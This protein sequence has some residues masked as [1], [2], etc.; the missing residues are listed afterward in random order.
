MQLCC[1]KKMLDELGVV[2]QSESEENDLFCWSANLITVNRKK[3]IV[4]V[5]DKNRFGYVLYGLKV[6]DLKSLDKF[7][8]EGIKAAFRD[9]KIKEE[10]I[11]KYLQAAGD[12]V[13]AR[14]RGPKYVSRLNKA[15]EYIGFF[16]DL[17]DAEKIIQIPPSRRIN[18]D[19]IKVD[20]YSD[21]EHPYELLI[22]DMEH[23]SGE[24]V[25]GCEAA[26][27]MVKLRLGR[28][29][30]SRRIVA[31]VDITFKQLHEILQTVYSWRNN[32]LHKFDIIDQHGVHILKVA[33]Y[34]E[35]IYEPG[36]SSRV[37]PDTDAR[38]LDYAKNDYKIIYTYDFGDNWEHEI[39]YTAAIPDYDKNYPICI[40]GEGNAPPEDVGGIQG[41]EEFLEILNYPENKEYK[42][43]LRWA[44][45]QWYR[46]FDI[47]LVNK[48]LRYIWR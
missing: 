45:S 18:N 7:I 19:L 32:H 10:I 35:D 36:H 14:T 28:Y 34:S 41:Y 38:L 24:G 42:N 17:M 27:V 40:L 15:C 30:A 43:T 16:G 8:I 44:Q 3:T 37:L 46:E 20:K 13:F 23:F 39:T 22:R 48:R 26:E 33:S 31:P 9:E 5:N 47:D 4:V 12:L 2:P 1:T 29:I 11:D 21:Y 25:I 6:K